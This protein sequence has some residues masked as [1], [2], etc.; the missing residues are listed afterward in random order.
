MK[1]LSSEEY[2]QFVLK[3]GNPKPLDQVWVDYYK[4]GNNCVVIMIVFSSF[5]LTY[6]APARDVYEH[7]LLYN[8]H[9]HILPE[10][11]IPS[12]NIGEGFLRLDGLSTSI[13]AL[14]EMYG[15]ERRY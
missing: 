4:D 2:L 8:G 10:M 1:S 6:R 14:R 9:I 3:W 12:I 5:S 13:E 15:D 11:D 7:G